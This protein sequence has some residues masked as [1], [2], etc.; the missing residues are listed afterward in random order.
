MTS[1][2]NVKALFV[3][4]FARTAVSARETLAGLAEVNPAAKGAISDLPGKAQNPRCLNIFRKPC[5]NVVL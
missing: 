2:D 1:V 5:A 3:Q 4:A